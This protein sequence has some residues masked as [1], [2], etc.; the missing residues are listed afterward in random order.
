MPG[1]AK[2]CTYYNTPW[3]ILLQIA[4]SNLGVVFIKAW[5]AA[6]N[7]MGLK[8]KRFNAQENTAI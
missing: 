2:L 1:A 7:K 3:C 8:M 4:C 6:G 5:V